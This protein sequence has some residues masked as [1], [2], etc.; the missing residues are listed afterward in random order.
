MNGPLPLRWLEGLKQKA[1]RPPS[2]PARDLSVRGCGGL[3][4][5]VPV[6]SD[7]PCLETL[8]LAVALLVRPWRPCDR[9]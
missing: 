1:G 7:G 6:C 2:A 8:A 9:G 5:R 3:V 4:D